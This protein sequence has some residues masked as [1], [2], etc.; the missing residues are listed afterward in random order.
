MQVEKS[1]ELPDFSM[2]SNSLTSHSPNMSWRH[3]RSDG[4][5]GSYTNR[6][7]ISKL[8]QTASPPG[9]RGTIGLEGIHEE[10]SSEES[11]AQEDSSTDSSS[12]G[13]SSPCRTRPAVDVDREDDSSNQDHKSP[14]TPSYHPPTPPPLKATTSVS[15]LLEISGEEAS[16]EAPL[17]APQESI[18]SNKSNLDPVD[19]AENEN[20]PSS[21]EKPQSEDPAPQDAELRKLSSAESCIGNDLSVLSSHGPQSTAQFHRES[22]DGSLRNLSTS[23]AS[24]PSSS[25]S[26]DP[27][28][29][30]PATPTALSTH[31][32]CSTGEK[33][34]GTAHDS[35]SHQHPDEDSENCG[36]GAVFSDNTSSTASAPIETSASPSQSQEKVPSSRPVAIPVRSVA[37]SSSGLHS[38][39]APHGSSPPHLE[40]PLISALTSCGLHSSSDSNPEQSST[41]PDATSQS[42]EFPV[43]DLRPPRYKPLPR[44]SGSPGQSPSREDSVGSLSKLWGKVGKPTPPDGA[45]TAAKEATGDSDGPEDD[46]NQPNREVQSNGGAPEPSEASF[47]HSLL[48]S[49]FLKPTVSSRHLSLMISA[50]E[51]VCPS[52]FVCWFLIM[53]YMNKWQPQVWSERES[54]PK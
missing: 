34:H 32:C 44:R 51:V 16:E 30:L 1:T 40:S 6:T 12:S 4:P 37:S 14:T 54:G 20:E 48:Y 2:Y 5:E 46:H 43:P 52:Y 29:G 31:N 3:E 47:Q 42:T 49:E 9:S 25:A 39:T 10:A 17:S 33:H 27:S 23:G 8:T 53:M 50:V 7:S 13:V 36:P 22:M 26:L 19:A 11:I 21:P 45:E 15:N 18:A 35:S 28:T 41:E 38:S 24:S